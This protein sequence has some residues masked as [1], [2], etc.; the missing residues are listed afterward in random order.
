MSN[1]I[2]IRLPDPDLPDLRA[3]DPW[4]DDIIV[5]IQ[6]DNYPTPHGLK[7]VGLTIDEAES[8]V[9][10]LMYAIDMRL[11]HD[12]APAYVKAAR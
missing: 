12:D 4:A 5:E 11:A 8:L 6:L 10:A 1:P 3:R 9:L 7:A 2:P